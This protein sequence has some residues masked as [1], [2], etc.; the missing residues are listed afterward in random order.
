MNLTEEEWKQ[1]KFHHKDVYVRYWITWEE[2]E[3]IEKQ[4]KGEKEE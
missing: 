4:L 1:R 3:E 2:K